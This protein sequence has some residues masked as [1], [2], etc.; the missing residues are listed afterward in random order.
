MPPS[1]AGVALPLMD[2]ITLQREGLETQLVYLEE[3]R[4]E[5]VGDVA[6]PLVCAECYSMKDECNCD[7]PLYWPLPAV[8]YKLRAELRV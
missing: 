7:A 2:D 4:L 6:P 5:F 3:L 1:F 8:V